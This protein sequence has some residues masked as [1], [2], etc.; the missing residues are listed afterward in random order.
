M[1]FN[2]YLILLDVLQEK[3]HSLRIEETTIKEEFFN[4]YDKYCDNENYKKTIS[5]RIQLEN[6]VEEITDMDI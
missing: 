2:T 4:D 5:Q 3:I 1:K 6:V